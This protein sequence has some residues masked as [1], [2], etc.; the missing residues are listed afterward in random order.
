MQQKDLV[1]KKAT[2]EKDD[3]SQKQAVEA[4]TLEKQIKEKESTIQN[5]TTRL[6]DSE[7]FSQ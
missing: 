7:T 2:S 3:F 5:L 6:Q 4:K 1:I